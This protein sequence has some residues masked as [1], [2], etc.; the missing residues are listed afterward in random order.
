[1]QEVDRGVMLHFMQKLGADAQIHVFLGTEI[2]IFRP[3]R[4]RYLRDSSNGGFWARLKPRPQQNVGACRFR[5]KGLP[6]TVA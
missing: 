4:F 5:T 1:M 3:S 6:P 2:C